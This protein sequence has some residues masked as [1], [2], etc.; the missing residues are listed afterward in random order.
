MAT[1]VPPP[2]PALNELWPASTN[3]ELVPAPRATPLAQP[4]ETSSMQQALASGSEAFRFVMEQAPT[5][6]KLA[7]GFRAPNT[8]AD[9]MVLVQQR[10]EEKR[11]K[12]ALR[13]D[14]KSK[15][16]HVPP[17]ENPLLTSGPGTQ[18]G[19][20][21]DAAPFWM[22]VEVRVFGGLELV[23]AVCVRSARVGGTWRLLQSSF[24]VQSVI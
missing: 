23:R 12:E 6:P 15:S 4:A 17:G 1:F 22:F 21:Q 13:K 3:V 10:D 8:L 20:P 24:V 11:K 2:N 16:K 5:L 9:A 7:E 19:N 14:L 18:I